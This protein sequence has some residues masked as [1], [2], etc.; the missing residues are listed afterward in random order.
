MEKQKSVGLGRRNRI[1]RI[2]SAEELD[3]FYVDKK[4]DRTVHI[5]FESEDTIVIDIFNSASAYHDESIG[6]VIGIIEINLRT[7]RSEF[8]EN[9]R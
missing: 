8:F 3:G 1:P 5:T 9:N 4:L 7:G 6:E 2:F